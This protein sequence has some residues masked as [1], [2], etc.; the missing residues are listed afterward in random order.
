[1]LR[2]QRISEY[3]LYVRVRVIVASIKGPRLW[4]VPKL[5]RVVKRTPTEAVYLDRDPDI[6]RVFG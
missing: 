2:V 3:S 6:L 1:M 4:Q 5:A